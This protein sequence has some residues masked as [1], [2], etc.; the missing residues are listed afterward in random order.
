[1]LIVPYAVYDTRKMELQCQESL[2][3]LDVARIDREAALAY[4]KIV[5]KAAADARMLVHA[6]NKEKDRDLARMK[7]DQARKES[8]ERLK[9]YRKMGMRVYLSASARKHTFPRSSLSLCLI[10]RYNQ[11]LKSWSWRLRHCANK[12]KR[13]RRRRIRSTNVRR[14]FNWCESK[15][16]KSGFVSESSS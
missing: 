7:M 13:Q 15:Q 6:A 1:M 2:T 10:L 9:A 16:S 11:R 14:C 3:A 4:I 8:A 12:S 5:D